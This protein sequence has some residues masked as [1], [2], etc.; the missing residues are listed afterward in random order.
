[1]PIPS[2]PITTATASILEQEIP[3]LPVNGTVI[4]TD[5][6]QSSD[7]N[8]DQ[9]GDDDTDNNSSKNNNNT[10]VP[11]DTNN[12]D[13]NNQTEIH[14]A[15]NHNATVPSTPAR[16]KTHT[17][18][19]SQ[20]RS[21]RVRQHDPI[22][23]PG[24][25]TRKDIIKLANEL[26]FG[27]V[28]FPIEAAEAMMRSR[29]RGLGAGV[30]PAE[31]EANPSTNGSAVPLSVAWADFMKEEGVIDSSNKTGS[32]RKTTPSTTT[33]R[34]DT[35]K[36]AVAGSSS[37]RVATKKR[38]YL[39]EDEGQPRKKGK[40]SSAGSSVGV[41][42]QTGTLDA[43][44][45]GRSKVKMNDACPWSL[46]T[47]TRLMTK[48]PVHRVFTSCNAA[49]SIAVDRKGVAYGWGRNETSQ[50]GPDL[51]KNVAYPTKLPLAGALDQAALGKGHT[52]F[53]MTDGSLWA[54]GANKAGQCGVRNTS[55]VVTNYR[56]CAL[57]DDITIKQVA[58]G[59]DFSVMLSTGGVVFS[60]GSSEFGQLGNGETGEY[61]VTASKLAF[62][63]CNVFTPRTT[64][65]HAPNEK[66]HVNNSEQTTVVPLKE[67]IRIGQIAC[68][69]HHTLAV[70]AASNLP[71]RVFSW[72]CG[73]YGVLGHGIQA[74][75]YFPRLIGI[76]SILIPQQAGEMPV[77]S[78]GASCSLLRMRGH[79]YYWGKHRSVG[80]A[81]MRPSLVDALANN[82]HEVTHCGAGGQTVICST[83]L[84][85]TVA[86]GQ[87]RNSLK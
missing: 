50:L 65:C 9:G 81:T 40:T 42:V 1:M 51:P 31:D 5:T 76:L 77:V 26:S 45:V 79:V 41:L 25:G 6:N 54:V 44:L 73:N 57:P 59:E 80:E 7:S 43:S 36:D 69:K 56:K 86:W 83:T 8:D 67:T 82:G 70:E 4:G 12:N 74:D 61:F 22:I 2:D 14:S 62:A 20:R 71:S 17:E 58:C 34:S 21:A 55:E 72:G 18:G 10:D 38:E 15:N 23:Y 64:F 19:A 16:S 49:H 47:P 3:P 39:D 46:P 29:G 66:L 28:R 75:E 78:A 24:F 32:D 48:I 85:Q 60:T 11:D 13:N 37:S 35:G 33:K 52:L 68:G 63:N 87:V 84:A 27:S 30:D 53:L